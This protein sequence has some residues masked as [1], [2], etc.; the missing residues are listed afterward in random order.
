M[1]L[2]AEISQAVAQAMLDAFETALDAGTA[3][4]IEIYTG[5][6]PGSLG[7]IGGTKLATLTCSATAF[8]SKTDGTPGAV[9]TF[10][11][12]TADSSADDTGTAGMFRILTQSAGTAIMDGS[13]GTSGA[14]MN[15]NTVAFTAGSTISLSA[16]TITVPES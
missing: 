14:D 4:I 6:Q 3:A 12:I 5:A 13:V 11:T 1:A 16:G 7:A 9:G 10:D 8:T 15:F 2:T